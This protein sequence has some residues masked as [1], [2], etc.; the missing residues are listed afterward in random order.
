M[1]DDFVEVFGR[2]GLLLA[3]G[4]D[5]FDGAGDLVD[6]VRY[7]RGQLGGILR[8]VRN[9]LDGAADLCHGFIDLTARRSDVLGDFAERLGVGAVLL[10]DFDERLILRRDG[11]AEEA[12]DGFG[13]AGKAG[14]S[15]LDGL[16][17]L[18]DL[19]DGLSRFL[20]ELAD[21]RRDDGEAAA[22]FAGARG[23]DGGVEREQVDLLG[24]AG[25]G[26]CHRANLLDGLGLFDGGRE[27]GGKFRGELFSGA[28][29]F[30]GFHLDVLR[31][32]LDVVGLLQAGAGFV[33]KGMDGMA[34]V[35][36]GGVDL[37]RGGAGVHHG[38]A[39][40]G[41]FFLDGGEAL[42]ELVGG[43]AERLARRG[44]VVG[45]ARDIVKDAAR[46]L[47]HFVHGAAE[48]ADFV[49]ALRLVAFAGVV[50]L[51]EVFGEFLIDGDARDV[52]R[53]R[54][55]GSEQ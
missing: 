48:Q 25:D 12:E 40:G 54:A 42:L 14:E 47:E 15:G 51:R 18:L 21:F 4:V 6:G 29:G 43:R 32:V 8:G 23:L 34:D 55:V 5:V 53:D 24:D 33:R 7:L 20:R 45:L 26:G 36:D 50:A 46:G 11:V 9:L 3:H 1:A 44:H 35:L 49:V 38:F 13:V 41:H 10:G 22:R 17:G 16:D 30:R 37:L 28:A 52:A 31:A 27:L 19:F 2:G 39:D